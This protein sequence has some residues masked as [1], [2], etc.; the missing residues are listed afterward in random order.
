MIMKPTTEAATMAATNE[1]SMT[2]FPCIFRLDQGMANDEQTMEAYRDNADRAYKKYCS[3]I[4]ANM[5]TASRTVFIHR[6]SMMH[7]HLSE[8]YIFGMGDRGK[9]W[10]TFLEELREDMDEK[11]LTPVATFEAHAVFNAVDSVLPYT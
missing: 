8:A 5:N 4:P 6:A 11:F 7:H 2:I 9:A 3:V 10:N 1:K